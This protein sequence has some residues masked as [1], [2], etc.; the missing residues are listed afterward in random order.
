[1]PP[2]PI[3]HRVALAAIAMGVGGSLL[4]GVESGLDRLGVGHAPLEG[5]RLGHGAL[6]VNGFVGTLIAAERA[7]ASNRAVT[8]AIPLAS[9]AGGGLLIAGSET[10]AT[11]AWVAAA[12]ALAVLMAWFWRMQPQLP[13]ALIALSAA[14]WCGGG[15]VWLATGSVIRAVPWWGAFLVLTILGERLELTRFARR[16]TLPGRGAAVLAVSTLLVS[17]LDREI[18]LRLL[19][20]AFAVTGAWLLWADTARRTIRRGGVAT[21]S[22]AALIAAYAWLVVAGLALV[23]AALTGSLYDA[24]LHALFVGFVMGAIFAHGPIVLPA[25][26]GRGVTLSPLLGVALAVLHGSILLRV[27]AGLARE[28]EWL[29]TAG[30]LHALAFALYAAG[31]IW[32]VLR[33]ARAGRASGVTRVGSAPR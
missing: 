31:M 4:V 25:L 18:G 27:V 33:H 7:R 6:M 23:R 21:F 1:M 14:V 29:R 26:T 13:V 15:L 8:A 3:P 11:L 30:N 22:A 10:A 5:A 20:V 12:A 24:T 19:G 2:T 17:L 28:G 9:A 16:S 32:G